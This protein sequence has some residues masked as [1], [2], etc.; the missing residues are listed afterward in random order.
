MQ[1][2]KSCCAVKKLVR[3]GRYALIDPSRQ[4]IMTEAIFVLQNILKKSKTLKNREKP[5]KSMKIGF[6]CTS[7][8][9]FQVGWPY[10]ST[11]MDPSLVSADAGPVGKNPPPR[12]SL[13]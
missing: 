12:D 10:F 9:I 11:W 2:A 8:P 4:V 5:R 1:M 13:A 7:I 6:Y 3:D